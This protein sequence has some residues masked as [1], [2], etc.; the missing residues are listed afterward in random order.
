MN[1]YIDESGDLGFSF[2]RPYGKG[3]SSRY[4]TITCL[5]TPPKLSHKPKRL[6][7]KLYKKLKHP[8]QHELKAVDLQPADKVYFAQKAKDLLVHNPEIKI[9]AMTAKKTRVQQ[10][11]RKD[12]NKLYNYMLGLLLPERIKRYPQVNLIPDERS[13]KV[14]SG[15]SLVDY[16]Q[17]NVWF[18]LKAKTIIKYWPSE[19]SRVLNIQFTDYVSNIIWNKY[20]RGHDTAFNILRQ[21][22]SCKTLFF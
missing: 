21:K 1:I 9:F 5:L 20:E 2:N 3:G 10:H 12:P 22:I 8:P 7:K 16:L 17:I 19:S 13:I 6:V 14:K 4:L 11:I 18:V 15:N